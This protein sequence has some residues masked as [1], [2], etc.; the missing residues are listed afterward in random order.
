[1]VEIMLV[2]LIIRNISL[3]MNQLRI[4]TLR[5]VIL[6]RVKNLTTTN[7]INMNRI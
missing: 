1:M 3:L 2:L 5:R 4:N 7:P 6:W